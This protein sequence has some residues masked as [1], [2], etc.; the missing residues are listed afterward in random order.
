M[1]FEPIFTLTSQQPSYSSEEEDGV[2]RVTAFVNFWNISALAW[3][4]SGGTKP[5]LEI[6]R[7]LGLYEWR[8]SC[9]LR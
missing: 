6:E 1:T 8:H 5:T 4:G 9:S 3:G 2:P 7:R